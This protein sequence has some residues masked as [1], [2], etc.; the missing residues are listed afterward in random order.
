MY[1]GADEGSSRRA[2]SPRRTGISRFV[3]HRLGFSDLDIADVEKI[4][5]QQQRLHQTKRYKGLDV[6]ES[7]SALLQ[8]QKK[9]GAALSEHS[10]SDDDLEIDSVFHSYSHYV[11]Q[12]GHDLAQ[13]E[14]ADQQL[15][16]IGQDNAYQASQEVLRQ[17]IVDLDNDEEQIL[18]KR[19]FLPAWKRHES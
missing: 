9:V 17:W 11:P 7:S 14:A 1:P 12:T 2:D 3:P 13:E 16:S 6:E 18:Y 19:Y 15:R 5:E 4:Q 8:L 10:K